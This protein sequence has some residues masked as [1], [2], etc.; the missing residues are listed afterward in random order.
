MKVKVAIKTKTRQIDL[1]T[2]ERIDDLQ[3]VFCFT[4]PMLHLLT[5]GR[6]DNMGPLLPYK[7][8]FI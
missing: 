4:G 7:L 6:F 1:K 2:Q 8:S 3:K 5:H